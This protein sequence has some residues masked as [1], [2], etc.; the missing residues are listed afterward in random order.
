MHLGRESIAYA[1]GPGEQESGEVIPFFLEM[2]D[3]TLNL[4]YVPEP[5]IPSESPDLISQ[6][7]SGGIACYR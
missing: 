6:E 5:K 1:S 4:F 7:I 3:V 2:R